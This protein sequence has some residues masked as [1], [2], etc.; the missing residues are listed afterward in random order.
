VNKLYSKNA[1][2]PIGPYSQGIETD[3][4]LFLS[5]QI[6]LKPGTGELVQGLTTQTHQV[7]QN[8]K[9]ILESAGHNLSNVVK[10]TVYLRNMKDF[11]EFNQIYAEYFKENPPAR[12]TVE[13]SALPKDA[14]IEID[15]IARK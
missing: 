11:T 15:I 10:T 13:V 4:F 6:G 7:L 2:E 8:V 9:A 14:L 12:T 1:P 5:G 3:G